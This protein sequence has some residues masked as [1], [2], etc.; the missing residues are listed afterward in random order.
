MLLGCPFPESTV[1]IREI[2]DVK[3]LPKKSLGL[4]SLKLTYVCIGNFLGNSV[5]ARNLLQLFL[6]LLQLCACRALGTI[7]TLRQVVS[8]MYAGCC[9]RRPALLSIESKRKKLFHP[10]TALS[11]ALGVVVLQAYQGVIEP[12]CWPSSASA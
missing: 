6:N 5:H 9:G 11:G 10:M 1:K 4:S 7:G 8:S 12:C 3:E 2:A